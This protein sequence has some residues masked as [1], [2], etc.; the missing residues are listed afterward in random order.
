MPFPAIISLLVS[1]VSTGSIEAWQTTAKNNQ[2]NH[3]L[4]CDNHHFYCMQLSQTCGKWIP[5][6]PGKLFYNKSG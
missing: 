5:S 3:F 1:G 6:F 4:D 2:S